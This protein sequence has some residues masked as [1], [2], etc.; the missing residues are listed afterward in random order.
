MLRGVLLSALQPFSSDAT[1]RPVLVTVCGDGDDSSS[2]ADGLN[3]GI[4]ADLADRG[5]AFY[6]IPLGGGRRTTDT[7]SRLASA[8]DGRVLPASEG[9]DAV[10]GLYDQVAEEIVNQYRLTFRAGRRG[11]TD[12]RV[13]LDHHETVA[14]VK[15]TVELAPPSIGGSPLAAGRAVGPAAGPP[16]TVSRSRLLSV[17]LAVNAGCFTLALAFQARRLWRRKTALSA[18]HAAAGGVAQG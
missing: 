7:L 18:R 14:E 4:P 13:R 10:F 11:P 12:V 5:V 2:F 1:N 3:H 15:K 17:L 6:A 8:V 9:P 16:E